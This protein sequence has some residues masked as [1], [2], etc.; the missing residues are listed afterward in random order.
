MELSDGGAP[1]RAADISL[2]VALVAAALTASVDALSHYAR[3]VVGALELP[4]QQVTNLTAH[5]Y[6]AFSMDLYYAPNTI[7]PL[8]AGLYAQSKGA[9]RTFVLCSLVASLGCLLQLVSLQPNDAKPRMAPLLLGRFLLGVAY[10]PLDSLWVTLLTPMFPTSFMRVSTCVNAS[11]RFGS[12][13]AFLLTPPLLQAGGVR[14]ALSVPLAL[15]AVL[16]SLFGVGARRAAGAAGDLVQPISSAHELRALLRQVDLQ[17][18]A[19]HPS[20]RPF[21]CTFHAVPCRSMPFHTTL[22]C[23]PLHLPCPRLTFDELAISAVLGLPRLR[24]LPLLFH[25]AALVL[26]LALPLRALPAGPRR[27]RPSHPHPR[28]T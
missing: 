16:I 27:C 23:T 18:T 12:V 28:G 22:P 9:G 17:V 14:L 4:L 8:A 15:G 26:W 13:L 7:M 5:E 25:D 10:E 3:D 2:T 19:S 11:Q 6:G 24:A 21:P 1:S 20:T